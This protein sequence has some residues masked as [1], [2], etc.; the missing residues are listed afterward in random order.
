VTAVIT[1]VGMPGG[2]KS[3]VGRYLARRLDAP[4]VDTDATI[5]RRIGCSIRSFFE[6]EG[7]E[8]FRDLEAG[9]L[10][11]LLEAGHGVV[12]TGGGIVLRDGNRRLLRDRSICVYLHST[13]DELFRRLR[14]DT[15]RPLLQVA[16]PLA[17]LRQMFAERD[18]LY[19][20]AAH[21]VVETGRPSVPT[22]VNMI[23]MQLELGGAIDPRDVPSPVDPSLRDD[24]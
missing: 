1:L 8:R 16:D 10:S 17:R 20:E 6:R 13:P 4:F 24:R 21:F 14:H 23:L 5:E 11:D 18:A 22:L 15:K 3:T 19:R 2:G 12:A 9:V 7:E